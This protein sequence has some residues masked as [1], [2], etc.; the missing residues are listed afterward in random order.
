[1]ETIKVSVGTVRSVSARTVDER[2]PVEFDAELLG[3]Y[4]TLTGDNDTR[5]VSQTLYQTA[6]GRL[7]VYVEEWSRWQ[8]EGSH[9]WLREVTEEDLR[10]GGEFEALGYES[11]YGRPLTLDE[12]LE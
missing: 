5:G 4:S 7:I 10:P 2:R 8:G 11:G 9:Y 1:M 3:D 6:D 12:A